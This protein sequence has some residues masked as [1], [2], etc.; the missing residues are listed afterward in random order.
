MISRIIK[1]IIKLIFWICILIALFLTVNYFMPKLTRDKLEIGGNVGNSFFEYNSATREDHLKYMES[2]ETA[3]GTLRYLDRW[4]RDGKVILLIHGI[5][6]SSR[7]RRHIT[8]RLIDKGYRVIVPDLLWYGVSKSTDTTLSRLIERQGIVINSLMKHLSI[9]RWSEAAHD[10]GSL[11]TWAQLK[12]IALY[13]WTATAQQIDDIILINAPWYTDWYTPSP[14]FEIHPL[15][16]KAIIYL[17]KLPLGGEQ[18]TRLLLHYDI[19]D[20]HGMWTGSLHGYSMPLQLDSRKNYS[21]TM[22]HIDAYQSLLDIYGTIYRQWDIPTTL[23][24]W[25]SNTS[26]DSRH[27]LPFYKK[28]FWLTDDRIISI[29]GGHYLQEQSPWKLAQ[30]ID[31]ALKKPRLQQ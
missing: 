1:A 6:S 13:S 11:V 5:P 15:V 27:Q 16:S 12:E 7:T 29:P 21:Y 28:D 19:P 22:S 25:M 24:R 14:L 23:V 2:Y 31:E 26:F 30:I 20:I 3:Y 9:T 8:A 18:L 4:P 10:R 17:T